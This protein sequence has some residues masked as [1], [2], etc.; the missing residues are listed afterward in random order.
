MTL[1]RYRLR[2]GTKGPRD[3]PPKIQPKPSTPI[4]GAQAVGPKAAHQDFPN[5]ECGRNEC[6]PAAVSNSLKFLNKRNDLGIPEKEISIDALKKPTG[7]RRQDGSPDNWQEGKKNYVESEN[8][9]SG[10]KKYPIETTV[11]NQPTK[12]AEKIFDAIRR[13]CDVEIIANHH[14]VAVT[15]AQ[16]LRNGKYSLDLTHD[17]IQGPP[18]GDAITETVTYNPNTNTVLDGAPFIAGE[19]IRLVVIECPKRTS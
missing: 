6:V 4:K 7:W 16:R 13:G 8:K 12:Y 9:K 18:R 15:G 19:K 1:R 17:P 10:K 5:Q 2:Q 14:C 3:R 11:P